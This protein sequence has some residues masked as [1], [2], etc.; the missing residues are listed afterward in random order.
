MA[1]VFPFFGR[2]V[3]QG[4]DVEGRVRGQEAVDHVREDRAIDD[5]GGHRDDAGPF[6]VPGVAVIVEDI[7]ILRHLE[8]VLGKEFLALV[9]DLGRDDRDL[10]VAR[11]VLSDDRAEID[12]GDDVGGGDDDQVRVRVVEGPVV[13]LDV[14][15][16]RVDAGAFVPGLVIHDD[17]LARLRVAHPGVHRAEVLE[18][19]TLVIL[20]EQPD[21][22]DA[23]IA[24]IGEGEVAKRVTPEERRAPKRARIRDGGD[25]RGRM[26]ID[27]ADDVFHDR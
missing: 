6:L 8:D 20:D 16:V 25:V 23:G 15:E 19:G 11:D 5:V 21:R 22:V 27:E 14:L 18:D 1:L 24:E 26:E 17:F 9:L 2:L 3:D 10:L 12:G 7:A 13:L 4:A